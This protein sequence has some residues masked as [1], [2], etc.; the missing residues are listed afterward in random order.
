[1]CPSL[2]AS[3]PDRFPAFVRRSDGEESGL[4]FE[5]PIPMQIIAHWIEGQLR[6]S[7]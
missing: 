5:T 1:L 7:A 6:L 2:D 3:D 4:S